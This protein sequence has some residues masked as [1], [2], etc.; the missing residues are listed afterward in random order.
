MKTL[1]RPLVCILTLFAGLQ[2]VHGQ[3]STG[4]L[5]LQLLQI[6][7]Q[8]ITV[9]VADTIE[10][11]RQGLMYRRSLPENQGM[12]FVFPT[13]R[14]LSFWMKNTWIPLSIGFFDSQRKLLNIL[15]MQPESLLVK[16]P[17]SY[18]SHGPAQYALEM[19]KGWFAKNKITPGMT[20]EWRKDHDRSSS[21]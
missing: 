8:I 17:K 14:P 10:S 6:G 9:E 19:N 7:D 12:L 1:G 21:K 13:Q 5:K 20:F 3:Q 15:D 4:Q 11:R 16:N 18:V 2:S